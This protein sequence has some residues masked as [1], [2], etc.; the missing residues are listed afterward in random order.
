M[1][2][3]ERLRWRPGQ[4]I[5]TPGTR[6][7]WGDVRGWLEGWNALGD[8]RDSSEKYARQDA[9]VAALPMAMVEQEDDASVLYE[10]VEVLERTRPPKGGRAGHPTTALLVAANNRLQALGA[11]GYRVYSRQRR[12][13]QPARRKKTGRAGHLSLF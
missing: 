4:I 5:T 2:D 11:A 6:L 12:W 1:N 13:K 7:R 9:H 3:N 10:L 8:R